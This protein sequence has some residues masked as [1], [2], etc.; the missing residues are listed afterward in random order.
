MKVQVSLTVSLTGMAIVSSPAWQNEVA[1]N[2][3]ADKT[4]IAID[5]YVLNAIMV[6]KQWIGTDSD[7]LQTAALPTRCR[8]DYY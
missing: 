1:P 5:V 6:G 3:S 8:S 4:N 2:A 7:E